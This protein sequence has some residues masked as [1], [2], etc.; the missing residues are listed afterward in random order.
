MRN[1]KSSLRSSS[2]A[3]KTEAR[4]GADHTHHP[5]T[6]RI[7]PLSATRPPGLQRS[8]SPGA[9]A[10]QPSLSAASRASSGS[11]MRAD[12]KSP[13]TEGKRFIILQQINSLYGVEG[14]I[15]I[16]MS[17]RID[18]WRWSWCTCITPV[19]YALLYY[20]DDLKCPAESWSWLCLACLACLA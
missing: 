9:A 15:S 20:C 13:Q 1:S 17:E 16:W 3:H 7:R 14:Q 4:T 5:N 8:P 11:F 10:G 6:H 2:G 12:A 19:T 18:C